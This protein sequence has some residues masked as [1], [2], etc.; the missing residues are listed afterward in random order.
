MVQSCLCSPA[1]LPPPRAVRVICNTTPFIPV[2]PGT[3]REAVTSGTMPDLV[4]YFNINKSFIVVPATWEEEIG[5][6]PGQKHTTSF[7][8]NKPRWYMPVVPAIWEA[9]IRRKVI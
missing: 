2:L 6:Q 1:A 8:K 9:E 3:D 5:V 4:K 7:I